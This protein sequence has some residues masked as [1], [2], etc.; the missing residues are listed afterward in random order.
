[1][2]ALEHDI[3]IRYVKSVGYEVDWVKIK[4]GEQ[5]PTRFV[6]VWLQ[7]DPYVQEAAAINSP[8]TCTTEAAVGS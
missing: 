7:G 3:A 2:A 8:A 1:M 6:H 5:P 4:A